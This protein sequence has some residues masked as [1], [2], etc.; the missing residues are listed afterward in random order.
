[1]ETKNLW[2]SDRIIKEEIKTSNSD[3]VSSNQIKENTE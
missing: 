3:V 1:M 2:V